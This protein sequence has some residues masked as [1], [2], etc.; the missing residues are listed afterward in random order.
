MSRRGWIMIGVLGALF[1]G[2]LAYGI[3][4]GD[5]AYVLDNAQAFCST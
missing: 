5:A 2:L 1:V 4:A 3:I